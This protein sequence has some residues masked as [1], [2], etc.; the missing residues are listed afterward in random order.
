MVIRP[1]PEMLF[2]VEI[3]FTSRY[4]SKL[5]K[6]LPKQ[7]ESLDFPIIE[8]HK[9][10]LIEKINPK[11]KIEHIYEI[12]SCSNDEPQ[13]NE[14]VVNSVD[15]NFPPNEKLAEMVTPCNTETKILLSIINY[16]KYKTLVKENTTGDLMKT[17]N[18]KT[19][20]LK[21][22]INDKRTSIT[23]DMFSEIINYHATKEDNMMSLM[24]EL[25][26]TDVDCDIQDIVDSNVE[27]E[28]KVILPQFILQS[29][30]IGKY[31]QAFF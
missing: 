28:K 30:D 3:I 22:L 18:I 13:T 7:Y 19:T 11:I 9:T 31:R 17:V 20:N 27:T 4:I 5:K 2:T 1:K 24:M 21:N 15:I 23:Q 26:L 25:I 10:V 8:E 16:S 12:E 14:E 6:S 29:C